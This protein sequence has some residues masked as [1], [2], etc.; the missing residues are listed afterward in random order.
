MKITNNYKDLLQDISSI[1]GVGKK[2][3]EILK[4]KKN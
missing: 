1:K 3:K 2:T 4:K